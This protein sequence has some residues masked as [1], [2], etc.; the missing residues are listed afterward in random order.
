MHILCT[1]AWALVTKKD[2]EQKSNSEIRKAFKPKAITKTTTYQI[3]NEF[4]A[5][6][7]QEESVQSY[8]QNTAQAD[9]NVFSNNIH[10]CSS[11]SVWAVPQ[12]RCQHPL[13][14]DIQSGGDSTISNQKRRHIGSLSPY[15]QM[16][17]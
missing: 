15:H 14:I 7:A 2:Q 9:P 4:D 17:S 12:P 16:C 11:K 3:K 5:A 10:N 6:G 13:R 8:I 1:D